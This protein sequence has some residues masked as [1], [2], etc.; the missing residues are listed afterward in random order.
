M[1]RDKESE[2]A[3]RW[4]FARKKEAL[5]E[6]VAR[7]KLHASDIWNHRKKRE[8]EEE[9]KNR[10]PEWVGVLQSNWNLVELL[11]VNEGSKIVFKLFLENFHGLT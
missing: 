3:G 7:E 4:T 8:E 6:N 5:E 2:K 11:V 10:G 9:E 1:Y